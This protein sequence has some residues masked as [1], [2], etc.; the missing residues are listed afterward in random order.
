VNTNSSQLAAQN[1]TRRDGA[2]KIARFA[3]DTDGFMLIEL[4]VVVLI[5]GILAAIAIP[6]FLS[7]TAK[8]VNVQ[9]K[10]LARSAETT[11]ET[12]ATENDGDYTKVTP[13][14]LH[15]IETTILIA[16]SKTEA[17]LSATTSSKTEYSVTAKAT[18][19][20]EFTISRTATGSVVRK[21]VSPITKTGC[22][23]SSAS[24]S[25]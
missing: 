23:H 11:A 17:Y 10:E 20:D 19:G 6:S 1:L 9:A 3:G 2:R 18:N 25:W 14:E 21:C 5:I 15:R 8:A 13:A 22:E 4:L 12:I 24:S 16:P 7:S